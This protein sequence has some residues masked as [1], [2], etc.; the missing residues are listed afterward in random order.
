MARRMREISGPVTA[1][2]MRDLE[3]RLTPEQRVVFVKA[4]LAWRKQNDA[5]LSAS[6]AVMAAKN[7]LEEALNAGMSDVVLLDRA[8]R[9]EAASSAATDAHVKCEAA[10][11][12]MDMALAAAMEDGNA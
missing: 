8:K 4:R 11:L 10:L 2:L 9:I 12:A 5:V 6:T 3:E 7:E 1:T